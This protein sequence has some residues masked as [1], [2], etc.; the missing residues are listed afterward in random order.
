MIR[1]KIQHVIRSLMK[2]V[3]NLNHPFQKMLAKL[4]WKRVITHL[5]ILEDFHRGKICKDQSWIVTRQI[6]TTLNV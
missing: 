1:G 6:G 5:T 4:I 2:S 3:I